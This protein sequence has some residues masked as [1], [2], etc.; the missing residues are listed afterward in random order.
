MAKWSDAAERIVDR[1]KHRATGR[2]V[3]KV[4]V[5]DL[6]HELHYGY[7]KAHEFLERHG[8][9][10]DEPA[11]FMQD[12]VPD[13]LVHCYNPEA[14]AITKVAEHAAKAHGD[15]QV[16]PCHLMYALG[17]CLE[18]W[19][20]SKQPSEAAVIVWL[21]HDHEVNIDALIKGLLGFLDDASDEVVEVIEPVDPLEPPP[22]RQVITIRGSFEIVIEGM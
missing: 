14:T 15:L 19:R 13:W 17:E 7:G 21:E 2:G 1:A 22:V 8:F 3:A 9:C 16:E 5:R 12:P 4:C 20:F 11:D 10:S 6:L 18:M